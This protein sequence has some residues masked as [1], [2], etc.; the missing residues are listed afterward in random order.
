[1]AVRGM[2]R[3]GSSG[4]GMELISTTEGVSVNPFQPAGERARWR[5]IYDLLRDAETG[6]VITYED[7]GE[8]LGLEP[9]KDRHAIQMAMRRAAAEH[10]REDKRAVD[11]VPNEGYRIVEAPE[12]LTLARKHQR[13][14]GRSIARGHSKVVNV[15]LTGV[16][17]EVRHALEITAQAFALQ[18]DFNRRFAVRQSRLEQAVQEITGTQAEDRK[19]TDEEVA[20]L[21][22]RIARLE[23][24]RGE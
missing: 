12:H 7:I 17:P 8:A 3:H 11:P 15:D 21:R 2:A 10:E 16:E 4:R 14:A 19:R 20:E 13:R 5:V 1:M 18:M 23:Q 22:E 6:S 9:D 24:E